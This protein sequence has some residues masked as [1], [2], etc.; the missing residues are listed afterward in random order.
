MREDVSPSLVPEAGRIAEK[1][2]VQA[3]C[4]LLLLRQYRAV[5]VANGL[6]HEIAR[7]DGPRN[8]AADAHSVV[9][10]LMARVAKA[11]RLARDLVDE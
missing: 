4:D 10:T 3:Q 2:T 7:L 11:D 9:A 6:L 5:L 1:R 8:C